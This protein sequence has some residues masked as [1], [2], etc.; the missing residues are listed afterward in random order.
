MD[1]L[2]WHVMCRT[3]TDNVNCTLSNQ[4]NQATC[5]Y[6]FRRDHSVLKRGEVYSALHFSTAVFFDGME[7][8]FVLGW[9]LFLSGRP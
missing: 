5:L 3:F 8:K 4:A 2:H 9:T 7:V 1:T 6:E